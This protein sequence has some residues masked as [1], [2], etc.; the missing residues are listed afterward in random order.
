MDPATTRPMSATSRE[1]SIAVFQRGPELLR[2]ALRGLDS[3]ALR[4]HPI[5]GKWSIQEIAF[6]LVDAELVG[7]ER[8]RRALMESGST[9]RPWDQEAWTRDLRYNE[10]SVEE[11]QEALQLFDSLRQTSLRIFRGATPEEW[12]RWIDH[13]EYGRLTVEKLLELYARHS[14]RHV[15]QILE[16]RRLMD[17][18]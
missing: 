8:L 2:E 16:R 17:R 13:P 15:E 1:T 9:L 6:H 4:A 7:A 5:Q 11:L 14:E 12:E 18:A 10:R 3:E